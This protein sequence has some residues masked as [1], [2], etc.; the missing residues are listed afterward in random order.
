ML[1]G[2]ENFKSTNMR[3]LHSAPQPGEI[4][5]LSRQLE[6]PEN[7][8][9]DKQKHLYST[10]A[11]SFL[12]GNAPPRYVAIV[13]EPGAESE[14]EPNL[15]SV[16][17][18]SAE[19]NF[20]SDVDLLIPARISGLGQDLLAETWHIQLMLVSNLLQPVGHR[21]SRDIYNILLTVG[22]YYH[23]L[24]DRQPEISDIDRLGLKAGTQKA[25]NTP[26]IA[27]FHQREQNW[28]DVLTIPV[29]VDR[30]YIKNIKFASQI[31]ND[32]LEI[33]RELAEFEVNENRFID[34]L[35][36]SLNKTHTLLSRWSQNIF[37][38]EWQDV[39]TLPKLA[40]AAR[41]FR[42][43]QNTRSNPDEIAATIE[44][45]SSAKD[46]TQRQLAA[47]QLGEIAVGN[48]KAIQALVSLLR[49]SSD[50]ETLWIAVESLRKIDP[51]NSAVGIKRVK[52]IDL[53]MEIAGK[54]V[55]LAVAFLPKTDGDVSVLLQVYPTR[56]DDRLPPD[57]KLILLD[58]AGEIVREVAA[59]RAD[60]YI[61]LKFSCEIGERFSVKLAL[62]DANF[63]ENF[64]I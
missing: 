47:K 30:T 5:E 3:K 35:S 9:I 14:T 43:S 24:V 25:S 28:S 59:R 8:Y 2:C 32:R 38:P 22:D 56:N 49:S 20:I 64:T 11:Q 60:V 54:T 21:L 37:E 41:S 61:Q 57:L 31:L 39:S 6:Y 58:D 44:K 12:W 34:L 1:T 18:L 51:E 13:T 19:T 46:E 42:D 16:M 62:N 36:K 10:E 7:F 4:W 55:A 52:A 45:L 48:S 17:V 29:A 15:I 26:E 23:G 50:D 33:E 53:G 40:I 63:S 27:L